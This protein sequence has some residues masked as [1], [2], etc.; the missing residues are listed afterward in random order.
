MW[1]TLLGSVQP[2]HQHIVPFAP[3]MRQVH[4]TSLQSNEWLLKQKIF[5]A[6]ESQKIY[7]NLCVNTMIWQKVLH[8]LKSA[9]NYFI[10]LQVM[11]IARKATYHTI[12]QYAV[13]SS[14]RKLKYCSVNTSTQ[15]RIQPTKIFLF[16]SSMLK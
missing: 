1:Q 12:R 9:I 2:N 8:T 16:L 6:D 11:C 15:K 3:Q 7:M 5:E 13:V 10:K 14:I 4:W